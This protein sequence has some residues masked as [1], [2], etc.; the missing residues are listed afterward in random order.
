MHQLDQMQLSNKHCKNKSIEPSQ[1]VIKHTAP[2]T[3]DIL[4]YPTTS[5]RFGNVNNA[6]NLCPSQ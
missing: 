1:C 2:S 3:M 5:K 4:V 6:K